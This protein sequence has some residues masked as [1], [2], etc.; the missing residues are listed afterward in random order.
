MYRCKDG[1][2]GT[3]KQFSKMCVCTGD[4]TLYDVIC[5]FVLNYCTTHW[6]F[7][8]KLVKITLNDENIKCFGRYYSIVFNCTRAQ[9]MLAWIYYCSIKF[10][11]PRPYYKAM[12]VLDF[13]SKPVRNEPEMSP[14]FPFSHANTNIPFITEGNIRHIRLDHDV[15]ARNPVVI[16]AN[17][18]LDR[19]E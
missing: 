1:L 17:I 10:D 18:Q 7:T 15:R 6:N 13:S 16:T 4:G 2:V 5:L 8:K 11:C 19:D 12:K 14:D 9:H 3:G